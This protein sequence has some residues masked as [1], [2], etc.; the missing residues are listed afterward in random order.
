MN[1]KN[2]LDDE[3]VSDTENNIISTNTD[4]NDLTLSV[5]MEWSKQHEVILIE[6]ADK[7]L[8]Y[9]WLHAECRN[10]YSRKNT[11]FTIPVIIMSTLTG[12]ANFA[13]ERIPLDYQPLYSV[14][15]GSINIFAGIITTIQQFL[16]VTE[17][18]E[19]HRVST[20]SWDKF[21]RNIKLEISKSRIE[22]IPP[23]QFLKLSKEEFDRLMETSPS[24]DKSVIERFKKKFSQEKYQNL[25]KPEICDNLET[26]KNILYKD[27]PESIKKRNIKNFINNVKD[28]TE[29]KRKSIIV[30]NFI[31][32]FN[33]EYKR[34]PTTNE[35][36]DNLEVDISNNMLNE[37][38]ISKK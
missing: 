18:N 9:R 35:I 7:A 15:V 28:N 32:T 10:N 36:Y 4:S 3:K 29:I 37:I 30:E 23:F 25:Y 2:N 34:E 1:N 8:C 16:K 11:W 22:R 12:T 13:Q 24:I 33:N 31:N 26:T 5:N 17:L 14:I 27:D 20:I 38:I 19:A 6:W 21:Y